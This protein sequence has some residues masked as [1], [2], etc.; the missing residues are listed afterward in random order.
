MKRLQKHPSLALILWIL[1]SAFAA[2]FTSRL[3]LGEEYRGFVVGNPIFFLTLTVLIISTKI[4]KHLG[5]SQVF[6]SVLSLLL[7]STMGL[8][9]LF[10]IN[11]SVQS[12]RLLSGPITVIG[13]YPAGPD[14]WFPAGIVIWC[15]ST[16]ILILMAV[17]VGTTA[18]KY[19]RPTDE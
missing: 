1:I 2:Y 15:A 11:F 8:I 4:P 9:S 18:G 3:F 5:A 14:V 17:I 12:A 19:L 6:I 7:F 13:Y 16:F 10:L